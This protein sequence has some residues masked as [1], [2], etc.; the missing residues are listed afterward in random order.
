MSYY[1]MSSEVVTANRSI[2]VLSRESRTGLQYALDC[3]NR[4]VF[5]EQQNA[6]YS[7]VQSGRCLKFPESMRVSYLSD[8]V[9]IN[10]LD[11]NVRR[12]WCLSCPGYVRRNL[13]LK[14]HS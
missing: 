1:Y 5:I 4:P 7:V 14:A 13:L 8:F 2:G 10:N 3:Q 9:N 6:W 11:E 12:T